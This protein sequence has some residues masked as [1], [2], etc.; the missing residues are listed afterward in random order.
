MHIQRSSMWGV[1]PDHPGSPLHKQTVCAHTC[2]VWRAN[3]PWRRDMHF[4]RGACFFKLKSIHQ[5][6]NTLVYLTNRNW[7]CESCTLN[8]FIFK[9][10]LRIKLHRGS[11]TS[12]VNFCGNT[13]HVPQIPDSKEYQFC[14]FKHHF[15][16]LVAEDQLG[17]LC[18]RHT[19]ISAL[20][21]K[22]EWSWEWNH[23]HG[24]A[25][26]PSQ[27]QTSQNSKKQIT[28]KKKYTTVLNL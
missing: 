8:W 17:S 28:K 9:P 16:N 14:F 21:E 1:I 26:C 10:S 27:Q 19:E 3:F 6:W 4:Y 5:S 11:I 2:Y 20:K 24:I 18:P 13:Q 23:V 15:L 7:S 22:D 12:H 25:H